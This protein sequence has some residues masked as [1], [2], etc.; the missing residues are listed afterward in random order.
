MHANLR[1]QSDYKVIVGKCVEIAS[2]DDR[3]AVSMG[4]RA[5]DTGPSFIVQD[6]IAHRSEPQ[7][8]DEK[9]SYSRS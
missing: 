1:A 5:L 6:A 4:F 3:K 2:T 7:I 8:S 9:F